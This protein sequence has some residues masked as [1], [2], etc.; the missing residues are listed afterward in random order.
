MFLTSW[1]VRIPMFISVWLGQKH[2][3]KEIATEITQK[4][5]EGVVY[6]ILIKRRNPIGYI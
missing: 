2:V 5:T 6:I 4:F 3:G 1:N